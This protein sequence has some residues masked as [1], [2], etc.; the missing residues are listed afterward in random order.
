MI[1]DAKDRFEERQAVANVER[2]AR[3]AEKML[4]REESEAKKMFGTIALQA[5]LDAGNGREE[6]DE[7]YR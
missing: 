1:I 2:C 6:S 3:I 7:V 5:W 4:E